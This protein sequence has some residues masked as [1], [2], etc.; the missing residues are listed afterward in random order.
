MLQEHGHFAHLQQVAEWIAHLGGRNSVTRVWNL[1]T[2]VQPIDDGRNNFSHGIDWNNLPANTLFCLQAGP[3]NA[4]KDDTIAA[5]ARLVYY[6]QK[7]TN[8][9]FQRQLHVQVRLFDCIAVRDFSTWSPNE[10]NTAYLDS[11]NNPTV[12]PARYQFNPRYF[13]RSPEDRSFRRARPSNF[14][15]FTDTGILFLPINANYG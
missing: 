12:P 6:F 11:L 9:P 8:V 5:L 13:L 14:N 3:W 7:R 4:I 2:V 15:V 10:I 1:P